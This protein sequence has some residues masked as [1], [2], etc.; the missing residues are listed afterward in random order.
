MRFTNKPKEMVQR[1]LMAAVGRERLVGMSFEGT[2]S[3]IPVPPDTLRAIYS[4]KIY[5]PISYKLRFIIDALFLSAFI[6]RNSEEMGK[7][8]NTEFRRSVTL[9]LYNLRNPKK[10]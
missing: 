3:T 9:F 10:R 8:T 1:L 6:T 2:E 5:F 7:L 4:K